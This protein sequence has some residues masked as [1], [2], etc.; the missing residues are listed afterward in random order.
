MIL[1]GLLGEKRSGK[2]TFVNFLSECVRPKR[3][4]RVRS[5]EVLYETLKIWGIDATR[6]NLTKLAIAMDNAYGNG[7]LTEVVR[8]RIAKDNSDIV[9]FD[10]V[11]WL[12]DEKLIRGFE[13]NLIIY[14]TSDAEMRW[15]R[16]RAAAEKVGEDKTTFDEFLKEEKAKTEQSIPDI[17][18]RADFKIVNEGTLEDYKKEVRK[19]CEKFFKRG[20][21]KLTSPAFENNGLI[22]S[23]YTC[24]SV[25]PIN[26]PLEISSIPNGTKSF[27]LIVDDPDVPK[28]IRPDGVF[29]H[30]VIFNISPNTA[31]IPESALLGICGNNGTG[32]TGYVGPCPPTQYEPSEHL[33]FFRVYAL[34]FELPLKE[35]A[36]KSEVLAAIDGH[37]LDQAELVGRY[38]RGE[39]K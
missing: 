2:G 36:S 16:G 5:V 37:I 22:P 20:E 25:A 38:K 30:W 9:I 6:M 32:K 29:D 13:K 14:V 11:R 7:T 31:N 15:K 18:S 24:D 17:G 19:F 4:G 26:P 35:G 21:M 3:V 34:D 8:Q 39:M 33:Y 10:G 1:I 28:A 23:K 27:A 12:T